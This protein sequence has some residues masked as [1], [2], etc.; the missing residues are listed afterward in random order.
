MERGGGERTLHLD[1]EHL[2]RT[3][4]DRV[5]P[6]CDPSRNGNLGNREFS[7]RRDKLFGLHVGCEE[8]GVDGCDS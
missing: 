3:R 6:S 1:L 5:N 4:E 2:N 8:E 7:V